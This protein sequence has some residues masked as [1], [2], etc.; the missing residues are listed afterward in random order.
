[1][2]YFFQGF[3][4]LIHPSVRVWVLLPLLLN[5]L[6]FVG[7][8]WFAID[9]FSTVLERLTGWLPDWLGFISTFLWG[10]FAALL[11]VIYGYT[12]TIVAN[13]LASPF[14][15]V[16]AERT[17]QVLSSEIN[18]APLSW[19]AMRQIAWR[20]FV[21]ELQKLLYFL[22]RI[23]GIFILC[24]ALSFIP[25]LNLLPPFIAFAW[26]AWSLALQFLDY[27]ADNNQMTFKQLRQRQKSNR[28]P[29]MAFGSLVLLG[30]SVPVLNLVV[31]P[32]AVTGATA[33]WLQRYH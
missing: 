19:L 33:L 27:P 30:T 17:Q 10:L 2:A 18:V 7:I 22:P 26:G 24:F 11:I 12:F 6:L 16:L 29:S 15:G 20:A 9:Q 13:V 23:I 32:A 3:R 5:T 14:Y 21:R 1:M 28:R 8:T 31:L 4:L 25:A